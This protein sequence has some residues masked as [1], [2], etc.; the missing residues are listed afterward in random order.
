MADEELTLIGTPPRVW[1]LLV[2][3][4]SYVRLGRYTPTRVGTSASR[5]LTVCRPP[6]HPHACGDFAIIT[7]RPY[8]LC[9][10]P[11]RVWGLPR[12]AN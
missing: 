6:V 4:N 5:T 3:R 9:G 10:T 12:F 11:P 7:N 2:G 8:I 1:G